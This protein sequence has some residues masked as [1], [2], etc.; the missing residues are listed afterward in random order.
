M[1][2]RKHKRRMHVK[3]DLPA[4][5][6]HEIEFFARRCG[7]TRD[8]AL[9]MMRDAGRLKDGAKASYETGAK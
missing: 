6:A 9:K 5:L 7:L 8:E 2:A 1:G 4:E 3:D